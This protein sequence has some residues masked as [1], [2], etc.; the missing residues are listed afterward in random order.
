MNQHTSVEAALSFAGNNPHFLL[1]IGSRDDLPP[2]LDNFDVID[3]R[4]NHYL[5]R[6]MELLDKPRTGWAREWRG[7]PRELQETVGAHMVKVSLAANKVL[8]GLSKWHFANLQ[9]MPEEL[10]KLLN[11]MVSYV[12]LPRK[13]FFHD[14]QEWG[15]N[16]DL[17]PGQVTKAEQDQI[18]YEAMREYAKIYGD[19]FPLLMYQSL[20]TKNIEN[21]II[22]NLDKMDAAVMALNYKRLGYDV[23][24]FFPYTMGKLTLPMMKEILEKLIAHYRDYPE[25]D[26]FIQ[27][28][29]LLANG[30]IMAC[31]EA[32]MN[33][34]IHYGNAA[35]LHMRMQKMLA[36][37]EI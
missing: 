27:Y 20:M 3:S 32:E 9:A 30:G 36:K 11:D 34:R 16:P 14:F 19:D 12:R 24:E 1:S 33:A 31:F 4:M 15:N 29:S 7:I 13:W 22:F 17:T 6:A 8:F 21:E 25:I 23:E 26:T 35:G 5:K 2:W 37:W 28:D 10:E 18:E